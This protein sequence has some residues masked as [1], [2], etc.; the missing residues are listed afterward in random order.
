VTLKEL[1][2]QV[3]QTPGTL[4]WGT[5][6][7]VNELF[8]RHEVEPTTITKSV[9]DNLGLEVMQSLHNMLRDGEIEYDGLS[10]LGR[11][12]RIRGRKLPPPRK[13]RSID[14]E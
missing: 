12:W 11:M 9:K 10:G 14:D 3:L 13:Y 7:I 5:L 1:V 2:R 6:D 4:D 8:V